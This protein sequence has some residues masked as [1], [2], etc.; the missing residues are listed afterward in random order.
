MMEP[1]SLMM[2]PHVHLD[3]YAVLPVP[4]PLRHNDL[5]HRLLNDIP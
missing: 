3:K 2:E 5:E 4:E 1:Q